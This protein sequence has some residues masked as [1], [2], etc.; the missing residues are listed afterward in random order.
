MQFNGILSAVGKT[1]LVRL[2]RV[3]PEI[4]VRLWAKLEALNPGGSAKDRPGLALIER[5]IEEGKI[6]PDTVVIESTSGNMG[7]GIAQACCQLGLRFIAVVDVKTAPANVAVLRAYGAEI[8]LVTQ[9]DPESG[10]LLQARLKRVRELL[11][12]LPNSFWPDQTSNE[13]NGWAHYRTTMP[14]IVEQLGKAPDFLFCAVGTCG[15]I[16][17][18]SEYVNDQ[19]LATKVIAVDMLGSVIFGSK[20]QRRLMPGFGS[21]RVPPIFEPKFIHDHVHVSNLDCVVGSRLLARREAILGGGSCGGA[22]MGV[23]KYKEHLPADATC[24]VV[25]PDRG[26]RYLDTVFNDDWVR[27]E[28]GDIAHLWE[29]RIAAAERS[30]PASVFA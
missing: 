17:G 19:R 30:T 25:L 21:G 4:P 5:G 14:E 11:D 15:T 26:E 24:V 16:R 7:I 9:P 12:T 27:R 1:P 13:A 28:I 2:E 29:E 20:P 23:D 18:C 8:D 10:E 3:F 6:T 22:L